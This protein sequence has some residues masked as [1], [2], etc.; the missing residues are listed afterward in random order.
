M[1]ADG[2][3]MLIVLSTLAAST[4][5]YRVTAVLSS[6]VTPLSHA[7]VWHLIVPIIKARFPVKLP[8]CNHRSCPWRVGLC[9]DFDWPNSFT[10]PQAN[11]TDLFG[12]PWSIVTH[13]LSTGFT[14]WGLWLVLIRS[15]LCTNEITLVDTGMVN[16]V[17][18][19]RSFRNQFITSPITSFAWIGH[20]LIMAVLYVFLI[21]CL[22]V[23]VYFNKE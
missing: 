5:W 6:I 16:L 23:F 9:Y 10:I 8:F 21:T 15:I 14:A 19:L 4:R 2:H 22:F 13:R 17:F 1:F 11:L 3:N 20:M 12:Y 7:C 18:H